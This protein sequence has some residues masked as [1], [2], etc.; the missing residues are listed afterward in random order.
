M[1]AVQ[2]SGIYVL[3]ID[4]RSTIN[5]AAGAL[6]ELELN[7]G[8][9]AYIG[10]AKKGL[11][12][13]L[14]RHARSGDKQLH[15]HIDHLLERADLEEVWIFP[16]RTG[17]CELAGRLEA[18]GAGRA[19]LRGFGSSDCRCPGHLLYLGRRKP[20]APADVISVNAVR[21]LA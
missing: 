16:L 11:A 13:R 3:V 15:W 9:Y 12:A 17:E 10:R 7:R 19:G 5:I 21:G 20:R 6:G 2:Q 4:V 1:E 18:E 14:A 8:Y